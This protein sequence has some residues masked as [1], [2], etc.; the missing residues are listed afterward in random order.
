MGWAICGDTAARWQKERPV[1]QLGTRARAAGH[2]RPG[3]RPQW[4]A[5]QRLRRGPWIEFCRLLLCVALGLRAAGGR[6]ATL[7]TLRDNCSGVGR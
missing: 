5:G 2:S 3:L 1:R 6:R 7:A 4:T